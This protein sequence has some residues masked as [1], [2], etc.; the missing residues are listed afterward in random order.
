MLCGDTASA[1]QRETGHREGRRDTRHPRRARSKYPPPGLAVGW[2]TWGQVGSRA[3]ARRGGTGGQ[4]VRGGLREALAGGQRVMETGGE[5]AAGVQD[6]R[7]L[8]DLLEKGFSPG[9]GEKGGGKGRALASPS[10]QWPRVCQTSAGRT[11]AHRTPRYGRARASPPR[12]T[13]GQ[14]PFYPTL[15]LPTCPGCPFSCSSYSS[16]PSS[17]W[18]CFSERDQ[19]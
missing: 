3:A 12:H 2:G 18:S 13:P 14:T 1:A 10:S 16:V 15:V 5:A 8:G 7:L 4:A 19:F 17:S 6:R 11:G 9:E